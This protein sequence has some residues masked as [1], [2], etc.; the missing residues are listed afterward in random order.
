MKTWSWRRGRPGGPWPWESWTFLAQDL[1]AASR[2]T[3]PMYVALCRITSG[4]SPMSPMP[5]S[6]L[7]E[8]VGALTQNRFFFVAESIWV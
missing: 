3:L 4:S 2:Q 1:K 8:A 6:F 5:F 7:A